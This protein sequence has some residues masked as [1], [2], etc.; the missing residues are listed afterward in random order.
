MENEFDECKCHIANLVLW[1]ILSG[2]LPG[3]FERE[4]E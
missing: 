2:E 4:A 3:D 1:W